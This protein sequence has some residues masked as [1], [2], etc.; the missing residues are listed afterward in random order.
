MPCYH[1]IPAW[2]GPP[3]KGGKITLVFKRPRDRSHKHD[4]EV[5]CNKC[6][7]CRLE[8]SR[9]W[10]IRCV[11]ES[12]LHDKNCFVTFTYDNENL[13]D[14]G[15]LVKKH[16]Q[17]FWK[18]LRRAIY[19]AKVRYYAAGE[20]GEENGRPHY[21]ACIFGFY[22]G[23]AVLVSN[24]NDYK[25]FHSDF[26]YGLWRKG[27]VRIAELNFQTAA[28]VA[29]YV[30]KKV[31]GALADE[32][33]KRVNPDTGEVIDLVPEFAVMS[34]RPGIGSGHF[35]KFGGDIYPSDE[36]V[37]DGRAVKPPKY[38]DKKYAEADEEKH[39]KLK[40]ER[41][42]QAEKRSERYAKA[43]LIAGEKIAQSKMNLNPRKV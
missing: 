36:V 14:N 39:A 38:Y 32:H 29:R 31:N 6:I 18:E 28:Y 26:V 23:D 37:I 15:T 21:H 41:C 2:Y 42:K 16:L 12:K 3:S 43:R 35:D 22:P 24:N 30:V 17:N 10:A 9:Q 5:P 27:N 8:Y 19:P 20:Y 1:P 7:G 25:L 13:P 40:Q 11:H 34:R 33:Y 4:I